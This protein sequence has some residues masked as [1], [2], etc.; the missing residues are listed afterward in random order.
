MLSDILESIF[1]TMIMIQIAAFL[2]QLHPYLQQH[3]FFAGAL[4][5]PASSLLKGENGWLQPMPTMC[6]MTPFS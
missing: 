4:S 6:C 3:V 5:E 1:T 2:S